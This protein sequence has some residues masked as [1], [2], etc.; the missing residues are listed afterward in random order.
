MYIRLM[1]IIKNVCSFVSLKYTRIISFL[2]F[3]SRKGLN[4]PY[5]SYVSPLETNHART[6]RIAQ[7]ISAIR[8][9]FTPHYVGWDLVRIGSKNDGGYYLVEQ[10]FNSIF[11]ISGGI[12]TNNDFELML[13]NAGATGLQVDYSIKVPPKPHK[14]L[15]FIQRKITDFGINGGDVSLNSLYES[16]ILNSKH[17]NS[18][19]ILKLDIEG[20]EWASLTEF[21]YLG[22]FNQI[23]VEFH[24]LFN[25]VD[26]Q[27]RSSAINLLEKLN[28]THI[29]VFSTGNNCC[30]FSVIAGNPFP[31]VIEA[32]FVNRKSIK[33]ERELTRSEIEIL[34]IPNLHDRACLVWF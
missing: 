33:V 21:K 29:C 31:N 7:E 2:I 9:K 19:N 1:K 15:E 17:Q 30:G 5:G 18:L 22:E 4:S 25:L 14:N 32:T 28:E 11:L 27:F 12:E 23:I 8:K 13:A 3:K 24:Q 34:N 20:S 26:K 16:Y 10:E 6:N